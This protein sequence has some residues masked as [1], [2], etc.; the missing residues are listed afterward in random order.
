MFEVMLAAAAFAGP[1]LA[2][3]D[4][5]A[6]RSAGEG[7]TESARFP[8]YDSATG[9]VIPINVRPNPAPPKIRNWERALPKKR[10]S[11]S[12]RWLADVLELLVWVVLGILLVALLVLIVRAFY[13]RRIRMWVLA[14]AESAREEAATDA[15]RVEK[16]PFAVKRPQSD[17]LG[18]ARRN[19]QA[20]NYAEAI[21]YLFSYQLVHLD[22]HDLVRLARG[23]TNRQYLREVRGLPTLVC[24]VSDT[25]I[26]FEEVFFGGHG[27]DRDQFESCWNRLDQFHGEVENAAAASTA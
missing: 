27:L 15:D 8:W 2:M 3:D 18:E 1:A 14:G 5:H 21:I 9:R 11:G 13:Q 7:L 23:K 20:G 24:I 10:S 16:L 25:M 22:K 12:W 4:Q 17:L 19:Y 26:R 6:V